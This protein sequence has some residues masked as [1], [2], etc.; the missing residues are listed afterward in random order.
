MKIWTSVGNRN[1]ENKKKKSAGLAV[2]TQ[3]FSKLSAL[4]WSK[5]LPTTCW[6][7]SFYQRHV[8]PKFLLNMRSVSLGQQQSLSPQW[9][10]DNLSTKFCWQFSLRS[11]SCPYFWCPDGPGLI[12]VAHHAQRNFISQPKNQAKPLQQFCS[13][14]TSDKSVSPNS[15]CI[16]LVCL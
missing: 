5:I 6:H 14:T 8:F 2:R 13:T 9:P 7:F 12:T 1:R 11:A 16:W 15:C 3:M 10:L 4:W